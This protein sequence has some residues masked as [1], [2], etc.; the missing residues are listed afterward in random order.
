MWKFKWDIF[1]IF[2]KTVLKVPIGLF[3]L[4][5]RIWICFSGWVGCSR[6]KHHIFIPPNLCVGFFM[7]VRM[8]N[9]LINDHPFFCHNGLD[10]VSFSS[11]SFWSK[12]SRKYWV[13]VS[14]LSDKQLQNSP[15][16]SFV[17]PFDAWKSLWTFAAWK[18]SDI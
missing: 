16:N 17:K 8:E 10:F 14:Y 13:D 9:C 6:K 1:E 18:D 4:P 3:L 7:R 2:S 11:N 15:E 5:N 12:P